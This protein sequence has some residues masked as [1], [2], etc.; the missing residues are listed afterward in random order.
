MLRLDNGRTCGMFA[1][2][3]RNSMAITS[4]QVKKNNEISLWFYYIPKY[5][6]QF[7]STKTSY[8]F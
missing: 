5:T 7:A 3:L 1:P 6:T 4:R 2:R 8:F